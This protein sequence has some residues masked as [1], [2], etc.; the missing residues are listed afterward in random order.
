MFVSKKIPVLVGGKLS[1]VLMLVFCGSKREAIV[2]YSF[3]TVRKDE[4]SLVMYL[5]GF[6]D[7]RII[8]FN[9]CPDI[10]KNLP[11]ITRL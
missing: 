3:S 6:C 5:Y 8:K 9:S 2:L 7:S 1:E 10:D 11:N 4:L